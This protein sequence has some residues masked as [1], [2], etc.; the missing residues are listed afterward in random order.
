MIAIATIGRCGSSF[1]MEWCKRMGLKTGDIKWIDRVDAGNEDHDTLHINKFILKNGA[2]MRKKI[3]YLDRDIVK[4]PYFIAHPDIIRQWA[5]VREMKVIYLK[6]PFTDIV[7]SQ[8]RHPTMTCPAYR[9]FPDLMQQKEQEFLAECEKLGILKGI[10]TFPDF[11]EEFNTVFDLIQ[12]SLH[13]PKMNKEQ[14]LQEWIRL[15]DNNKV[16]IK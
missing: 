7:Q 2:D 4:D 5:E 1:L 16:H 10:L 15:V 11:L 8:K 12:S 6:R 13:R 14:G 9:C 3:K